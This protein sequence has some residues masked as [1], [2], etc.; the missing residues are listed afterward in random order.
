MELFF[1][2]LKDVAYVTEGLLSLG[3]PLQ[4]RAVGVR[5]EHGLFIF[6]VQ[7]V[8]FLN[9][10]KKKLGLISGSYLDIFD[11]DTISFN[12]KKAYFAVIS[13]IL[14]SQDKLRSIGGQQVSVLCL[15]PLLSVQNLR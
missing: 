8:I 5:K 3:H 13:C 11:I 10:V 2:H 7:S 9:R 6:P 15:I 14:H 4:L 12:I 1:L